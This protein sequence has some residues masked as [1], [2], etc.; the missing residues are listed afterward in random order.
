MQ[1]FDRSCKF[2]DRFIVPDE[3][4]KKKIGIYEIELIDNPGQIVVAVNP[5]EY[6]KTIETIYRL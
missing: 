4:L 3:S 6:F 5:Q 2:W 1:K